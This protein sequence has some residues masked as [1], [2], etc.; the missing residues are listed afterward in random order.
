VARAVEVFV[1]GGVLAL[2]GFVDGAVYRA[3]PL[4]YERA[5]LRVLEGCV[6]SPLTFQ[7]SSAAANG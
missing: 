4:T 7:V 1:P 6:I 3:R 5:V 2:F